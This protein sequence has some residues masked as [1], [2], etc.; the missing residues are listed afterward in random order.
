MLKY[1]TLIGYKKSH[2]SDYVIK[3]CQARFNPS[4]DGDAKSRKPMEGQK[5]LFV[6]THV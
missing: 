2:A 6:G 1:S 4:I 5:Q 3:V